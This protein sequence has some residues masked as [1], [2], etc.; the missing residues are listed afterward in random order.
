MDFSTNI[1]DQVGYVTGLRNEK[2]GFFFGKSGMSSGVSEV[3][4]ILYE[5]HFE[6]M[7]LSSAL[8]KLEN[9]RIAF[10]LPN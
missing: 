3:T 4:G 7:S 5:V 1:N 9:L 6:D 2:T 10:V 8:I